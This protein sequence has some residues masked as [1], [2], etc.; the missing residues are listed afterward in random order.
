MRRLS[1]GVIT[2]KKTYA[3]AEVG[4]VHT[5]S[6]PSG[7]GEQS[8]RNNATGCSDSRTCHNQPSRKR[9]FLDIGQA[10]RL[11]RAKATR[12]LNFQ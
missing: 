1:C 9:G 2:S 7:R 11:S 6:P 12:F 3:I 4:W 10:G 8:L 5:I